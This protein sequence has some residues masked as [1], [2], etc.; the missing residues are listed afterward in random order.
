MMTDQA[1]IS[2]DYRWMDTD[3][4]EGACLVYEKGWTPP[5]TKHEPIYTYQPYYRPLT[6][7]VSGG[8]HRF[9]KSLGGAI[10]ATYNLVSRKSRGIWEIDL[11]D[12]HAQQDFTGPL[13]EDVIFPMIARSRH[14]VQARVTRRKGRIP[15]V[16]PYSLLT[17]EEEG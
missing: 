10:L 17:D 15:W 8:A 3:K 2:L 7:G 1:A 9:I 6:S 16:I 14:A 11:E 4:Q 13:F 12:H 5:E